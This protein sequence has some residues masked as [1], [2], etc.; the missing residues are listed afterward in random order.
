[1][2]YKI[3]HPYRISKILGILQRVLNL[4][5]FNTSYKDEE[6]QQVYTT[7]MDIQERITKY[8]IYTPDDVGYIKKCHAYVDIFYDSTL[9]FRVPV[10]NFTIL[11]AILFI[12]AII[13]TCV[14]L[15]NAPA[16]LLFSSIMFMTLSIMIHV[17]S[18]T[19]SDKKKE[20]ILKNLMNFTKDYKNSM[21]K[22]GYDKF[23]EKHMEEFS[24]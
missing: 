3:V 6:H 7:L 17:F 24:S 10:K 1:M 4:Y 9:I 13:I 11:M 20:M 18:M 2:V 21:I 16:V 12:N 8:R 23:F 15:G 22:K 14:I 5:P 19:T